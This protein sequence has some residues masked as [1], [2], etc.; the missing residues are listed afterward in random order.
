VFSHVLNNAL[1]HGLESDDER[2][3]AGKPMP[4][5]MQLSVTAT[6]EEI[7]VE[8]RDDGRGIDWELVREHAAARKLPCRDQLDLERALFADR[9][10]TREQVSHTS[11][12]G[13]GLAAVQH[14][15]AAMGGKIELES[16]QGAGSTWRFRFAEAFLKR[17]RSVPP[18]GP[19][20]NPGAGATG[21]GAT[22][23]GSL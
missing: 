18:T 2:R 15:V 8:V 13:V 5:N 20:S 4:G 22:P 11:G 9:F 6:R 17:S 16:T 14:V 12:R 21:A 3:S 7:V 10:T 23:A 19:A 1:D